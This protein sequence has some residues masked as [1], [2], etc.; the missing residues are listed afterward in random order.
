MAINSVK[1]IRDFDGYF[2]AEAKRIAAELPQV[3]LIIEVEAGPYQ[4]CDVKYSVSDDKKKITLVY[5]AAIRVGFGR[6]WHD[7]VVKDL[8]EIL[9]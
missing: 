1:V 5:Y 7:E 4:R 3:G 2:E 6:L 9:Q 8:K